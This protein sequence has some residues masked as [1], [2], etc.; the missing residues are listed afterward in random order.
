MMI[1]KSEQPDTKPTKVKVIEPFRIVH[2]AKE[3]F[4][5][6]SVNAP[7]HLAQEW[8]TIRLGRTSQHQGLTHELSVSA[9]TTI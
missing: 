8:E 7:A 6:D 1:E 2:N 5:G 9:S 4:A 3:Y